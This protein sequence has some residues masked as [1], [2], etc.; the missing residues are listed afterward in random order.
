MVLFYKRRLLIMPITYPQYVKT[1]TQC[2]I[3]H[4]SGEMISRKIITGKLENQYHKK[5]LF[6]L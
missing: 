4:L 3:E 5:M 1:P 2:V 6:I